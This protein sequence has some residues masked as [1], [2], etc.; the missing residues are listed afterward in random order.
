M[1]VSDTDSYQA[2]L[3]ELGIVSDANDPTYRAFW[4]WGRLLDCP[5]T[6][7]SMS[8][9]RHRAMTINA[10]GELLQIAA[11]LQRAVASSAESGEDVAPGALQSI[12]DQ[13]LTVAGGPETLVG[14]ELEIVAANIGVAA[15]TINMFEV[16]NIGDVWQEVDA[17]V[18]SS[19][20]RTDWDY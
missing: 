14:P 15:A 17:S 12:Q 6:Q 20:N 7:V 16:S 8:P 5:G 19:M 9:S 2:A 11:S 13:L 4:L 18:P 1:K 3:A 10:L